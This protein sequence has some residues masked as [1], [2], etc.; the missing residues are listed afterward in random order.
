M[1]I[2]KEWEY[3]FFKSNCWFLSL[4]MDFRL[5]MFKMKVENV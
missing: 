4:N 3:F 2:G 5:L 1:V